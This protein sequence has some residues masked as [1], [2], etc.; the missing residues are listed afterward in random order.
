MRAL[1]LLLVAAAAHAAP[2]LP[3]ELAETGIGDPGTIAF[4]PQYPLWS[5]GTTK[6]RWLKLPPGTSVDASRVD[7]WEFPPG[8]KAWKEFSHGRRVETRFIERLADGSWRFAAYVWNAQGTEARLAAE[9]GEW[10]AVPEAPGGRYRVPSRADCLACHEGAAVPILGY[11]AVQL[12]P[13]RIAA[14]TPQA[15]AALGYLHGNCGHCHNDS[16]PLA[17]VE[18]SL[19]QLAAAPGASAERTARSLARRGDDVLR[20]LRSTSP[21]VRMPPIGVS[22]IDAEG[23]ALVEQLISHLRQKEP[24]P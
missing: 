14:P 1:I 7:A 3:T 12:S 4:T 18:L 9:K 23:V 5:D 20:R 15:R 6:R 16:G 24:P 10:V 13:A 11:S 8:T 22:V 17:G 19:A 2:P 21:Y